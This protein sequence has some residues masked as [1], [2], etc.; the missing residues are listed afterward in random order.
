MRR[1]VLSMLLFAALGALVL[2]APAPACAD[3]AGLPGMDKVPRPVPAGFAETSEERPRLVV[4]VT[5]TPREFER[6]LGLA[7]DATHRFDMKAA[8]AA[9]V[10]ARAKLG[11]GI[12]VGQARQLRAATSVDRVLMVDLRETAGELRVSTRMVWLDN[13]E[14]T[15][16]LALFGKSTNAR[17]LAIQLATFVRRATPLR[18]QVR[19]LVE[20]H[21]VLDL[22]ASNG[23]REG[24]VFQIVRHASN[25]KPTLI[26]T[27]RVTATEPF[28]AKAEIEDAVKEF[29]IAPGDVAIEQSSELALN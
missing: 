9:L 14:V 6:Q 28:A 2:G 26:G 22:G 3:N 23:V 11:P 8:P 25:L 17:T 20:D 5:G 1:S 21:V 12:S 16:E 27:V 4:M 10:A 7:L 29:E 19:A 15:R 24:A 18:C 13:G